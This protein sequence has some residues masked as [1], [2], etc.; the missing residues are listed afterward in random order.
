[1]TNTEAMDR[2]HSDE[3]DILIDITGFTKDN[4]LEICAGRPAKVQITWL[5][6]PGTSGSNFFD[7]VIADKIVLPERDL[8]YYSEKAIYL[9]HTYQI[10]NSTIEPSK[11]GFTKKRMGL[12]EKGFIFS[13]FN[14]NYK[15]EPDLWKIWMNILKRVPDSYLWMWRQDE[16]AAKN[17]IKEAKKAGIKED[18]LIFGGRFSK[19]NHIE[20][21]ALA[22]LGL[23]TKTYGGHTTTSDSLL[24]GV[25]VITIMGE[26][27]AS[28]VCASLLTEAGIP[29]MIV[30]NLNEYED[31]AVMLAENPDKLKRISEK[32]T[33]DKLKK[34]LYN[35]RRFV[36][37]L[38]K[39]YLKVWEIYKK[40]ESPKTL[41]V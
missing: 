8:K 37:S 39:A 31:F 35:T 11:E 5:G 40:G 23:D 6:F 32:I 24:A 34:N 13:S 18:R 14:Q 20:R 3:I 21:L 27:F 26:H 16:I 7:Y 41:S 33:T 2:I 9:P 28:R 22:D 29:E 1:M 36:E 30:K 19:D 25:P 4:R 17:L 12:P 10:N 15:I 38:E